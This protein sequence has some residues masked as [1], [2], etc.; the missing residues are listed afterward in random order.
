MTTSDTTTEATTQLTSSSAEFELR[1]T[2]DKLELYFCDANTSQWEEELGDVSDF[3]DHDDLVYEIRREIEAAA[4]DMA[5]SIV[6]NAAERYAMLG[7][8]TAG[9]VASD[10]APTDG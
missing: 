2:G 5:K 8:I 10:A 1:R 7:E 3:K 9:P 4:E 6:K